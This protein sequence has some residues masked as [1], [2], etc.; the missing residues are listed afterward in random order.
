M[1]N[2]FFGI[3]EQ[4]NHGFAH[5]FFGKINYDFLTN[6][7]G[8]FLDGVMCA[9]VLCF[10]LSLA[11]CESS[12][13]ESLSEWMATVRRTAHASPLSLPAPLAMTPSVY[14]LAGQ[15]DPFDASKI[16]MLLDISDHAGVRPDLKRSREPLESYPLDQFR[17]VGSLGRPGQSVALVEVGKILYQL[18]KGNHLGQDLGEVITIMDGSIEIEET[19]QE[20]NGDWIKRRVQLS[21]REAK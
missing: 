13:D 17:M 21:M 1:T 11:A 19:I 20:A 7:L 12:S 8:D 15:V 18:R 16:S 5:N 10:L 9:I 3:R 14:E 4:A 2:R 6:F